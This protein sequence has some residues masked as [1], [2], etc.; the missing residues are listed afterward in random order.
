[1]ANKYGDIFQKQAVMRKVLLALLPL[2]AASVY[3]FGW[4]SLAML[5]VVNIFGV[6]SE[7][8]FARVYKKKVSESCRNCRT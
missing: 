5:A 6:L 7:F 8:V 1:M 2:A 4:R 3:F